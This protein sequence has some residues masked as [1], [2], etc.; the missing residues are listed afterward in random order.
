L[1]YVSIVTGYDLGCCTGVSIH[2]GEDIL[3]ISVVCK[4][5]LKP[6]D[7]YEGLLLLGKGP[8][9]KDHQLPTSNTTVQNASFYAPTSILLYGMILK[10]RKKLHC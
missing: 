9:R 4:P 3:I 10:R 8:W 6:T 5:T 1:G 7:G 2:P